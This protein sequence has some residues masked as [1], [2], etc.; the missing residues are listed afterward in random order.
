MVWRSSANW[1]IIETE[2]LTAS[3]LISGVLLIVAVEALSDRSRLVS[4]SSVLVSFDSC[5]C[6]DVSNSDRICSISSLLMCCWQ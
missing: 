4:V 5:S 1:L 6:D 3:S 2:S